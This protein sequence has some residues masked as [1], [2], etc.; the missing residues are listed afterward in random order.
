[1]EC[2]LVIMHLIFDRIF[3]L[4]TINN[5]DKPSIYRGTPS[6]GTPPNRSPLDPHEISPKIPAA[7]ALGVPHFLALFLGQLADMIFNG[8]VPWHGH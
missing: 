7:D 8:L 3:P 6:F 5:H 2:S 4:I 1:M